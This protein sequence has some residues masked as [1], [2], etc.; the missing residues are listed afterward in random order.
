MSYNYILCYTRTPK[1]NL[2]YTPKLAYS[3][4]LAYSK[5]GENF[6]ALNHNS[7]VLF[8]KATENEDS[9][10][11]AKS[12]KNPYLFRLKDGSFGVVA[13]RTEPNGEQDPESKGNVLFFTSSDLL[14]YEEVGLI[15]LQTDQYIED[16][17]AVYRL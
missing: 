16:V 12:L 1:E 17:L 4:H 14:Q 3:M 10:L 2:I 11:N 5:D 8:A 15:D 7:G 6:E 13:V 9:S